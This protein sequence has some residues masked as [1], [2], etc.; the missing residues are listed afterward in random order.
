MNVRIFGILG[1]ILCFFTQPSFS[2][3]YFQ[4]EV[5]Y[6]IEVTLD[7]QNHFLHGFVEIDYT[8]NAAQPLEEIH[9]H[10]WPNAYKNNQTTLAREQFASE[11]KHF[12][13]R[14]ESQRGFI[15]SLRFRANGEPVKW[16][17]HPDHI[18][19]AILRLNQPLSPGESITLTTPFRVKIPLGVT[20]RFGHIGQSYKITQWYPKPAVFDKRGWH[21]MPYRDM[22]EFYSEY[23]NFQVS[24]TLPE[25]YVVAATGQLQNKEELRWLRRKATD[26]KGA[27]SFDKNDMD[28]PPSAD[29][30]KT[31]TYTIDNAHDFAWFAD[32]RYHVMMDSVKLPN[33][34]RTVTTWTYFTNDQAELWR[35]AT[36]YI[37]HALRYFSQWYGDYAWDNCSAVLGARGSR[38]SGMEYP[39]ITAIGYTQQAKMLEQV[40][41]HEVGHNWFYGMLGFNERRYPFLDEGLTTFSE[42]RYMNKRYPDLHLYENFGMDEP[43]ARL[44]GIEHMGYTNQHEMIYLLKARE[45]ADQATNI[46][47]AEYTLMNYMA[48]PYSKAGLAFR[49]LKGYLGPEAFNSTMQDFFHQWKFKHP[50]PEDLRNAIEINTD[51]ELDWFFDT[52]L[53]TTRKMDYKIKSY[54]DGRL[55]VKNRKETAAPLMVAGFKGQEQVFSRW[56]EGFTGKRW[57]D[58]PEKEADRYVIDPHHEMLEL[59]RHNNTIRTSGLLPRL[60]PLE[61][62]FLG[63]VN[64]PYQTQIHYLPSLAWNYYDKTMVGVSLYDAL[65]PADH[66]DYF[67]APLYST[68]KKQL[69]GLGEITFNRYPDKVLDKI[70][71]KVSGKRFAYREEQNRSFERLRAEASFIWKKRGSGFNRKNSVRYAVTR[72]SNIANMFPDIGDTGHRWYH[73]LSL[74]H[75]NTTRS[76]H[77]Y[78]LSAHLEYGSRFLKSWVE[79]NYKYS[80]YM[81][82]GLNIRLF[83]GTFLYKK[84]NL[85]WYYAYHL[86][87]SNG[88][89][90]Y[91]FNQTFLGRFENPMNENDNQLLAQ[92]FYPDNGGFALY[93]PLGISRNWLVSLNISSSL[94]IIRDIPIQ[95]YTN[96]GAFGKS[97]PVGIDLA[98]ERWALETGIKLSFLQFLDVYFPVA[99]SNNLERASDYV[100]TRY[101]EK[102]RFHLK[103]D[104]F[105]P[106]TITDQ[107]DF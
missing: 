17:H 59:Y 8:N 92:Q 60:E 50:Y 90:D 86:S 103:F 40:I 77:P 66:F 57:L 47:S 14:A 97:L 15:D 100:H 52:L 85:P 49:H 46:H 21:A 72:A 75:D 48:I 91:T 106:S 61:I 38:G 87:G 32:K 64:N 22:G 6:N 9:F 88:F 81:N 96:I 78:S 24:I 28:F 3:E 80:Y 94:P 98:N 43:M 104:L 70:E 29:Q 33:S 51:R 83:G 27:F 7:D 5:N 16:E 79:A 37:N 41:I 20:S 69:S 25:N 68:G 82:E 31:L 63:F 11:G 53:Q 35:N 10:L 30:T 74:E 62:R 105:K 1:L 55:H 107:F 54:R 45:N 18:D 19:M 23:G 93:S 12:L 13:F 44:A 36:R 99:A 84:D 101:G 39:T 56:Y 42:I 26:T 65:L 76:I 73:K 4:Q 95:A 58:M 102:I 67:L 89:Y 34:G 2:Q 71:L